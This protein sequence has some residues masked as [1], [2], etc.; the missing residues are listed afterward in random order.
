[1]AAAPAAAAPAAPCATC[2][3]PEAPAEEEPADEPTKYFIMKLL[4]GSPAGQMLSDKGITIQ[5]WV[6]MNYTASSASR[7]NFPVTFNTRANDFQMNQLWLESS[8]AIDTS[9]KEVQFG[10]RVAALYGE[11]YALTLPRGLY[12]S[13]LP[14]RY[15]F[16]PVYHYGE[17][18]L[19]N[20]GGEG[21]TLRVGRW[22]TLIGYEVIEATGTPFLTKSY[23]FQFNPFTHTGAMLTTQLSDTWTMY[24][25]AVTGSDVYIDPA[26]RLTYVGG[27]KWAP[28]EGDTSV[29]LN[30]VVTDPSFFVREGFQHFNSYNLLIT[31]KCSDDLTYVLDATYSH[32]DTFAALNQSAN[33]YGFANYFLYKISDTLSSN[34]RVELFEDNKGVRTGFRG[35]YTEV[36]YG[37]AWTPTDAVIVRPT[38]RYDYNSTSRPFEGDRDLFTATF[39]LIIRF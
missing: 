24:H 10:Y 7:N 20:L 5:G 4:E 29:A 31:H 3:Q 37:L 18:F 9:K 12:N 25:G 39:D 32:A 14:D 30:T 8:K 23:N 36:T 35:L 6:N 34:F 17:I 13:Q 16:D 22:G 1:M 19:P 11:D 15:G 28:P 27:I 26:A 38:V 21:S 2:A 33:W